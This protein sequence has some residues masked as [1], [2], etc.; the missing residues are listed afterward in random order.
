[1]SRLPDPQYLTFPF[2]VEAGGPRTSGRAD[3]VKE[4]IMQVIFTASR[5][6]IFRPE[7]GAGLRN[8]VMEPNSSA[9]AELTRKRLRVSL[10]EALHGEVDPKTLEV[11]ARVEEERLWITIRYTLATIGKRESLSYDL[12]T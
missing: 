9:L 6:R 2:R 12:G 1:M 11:E 7:F 4:Q 5:E 3:H 10:A 8:L